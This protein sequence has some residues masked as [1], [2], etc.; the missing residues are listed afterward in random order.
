LVLLGFIPELEILLGI[1]VLI[2]M[3]SL[4]YLIYIE[5]W[6][7]FQKEKEKRKELE[8]QTIRFPNCGFDNP[9]GFEFCGS[10][11]IKLDLIEAYD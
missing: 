9:I 8:T 2:I 1:G 3:I 10:C 6:L 7:L 5:N 4:I 11:G